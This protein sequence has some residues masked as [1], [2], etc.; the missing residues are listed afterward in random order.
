MNLIIILNGRSL[1]HSKGY[2]SEA[3]K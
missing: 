3:L 2:V 1:K